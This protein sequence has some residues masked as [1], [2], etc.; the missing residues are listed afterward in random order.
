VAQGRRVG[1]SRLDVLEC[2][3]GRWGEDRDMLAYILTD[4]MEQSPSWEANRF[5]TGQEIPHS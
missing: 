4:S 3:C 2:K 1:H 5:L